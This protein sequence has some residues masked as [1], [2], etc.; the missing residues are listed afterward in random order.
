MFFPGNISLPNQIKL[1]ESHHC[2]VLSAQLIY[3]SAFNL[4]LLRRTRWKEHSGDRNYKLRSAWDT[5]ES[6]FKATCKLKFRIQ[7]HSL[8]LE[9][10]WRFFSAALNV[11]NSKLTRGKIVLRHEKSLRKSFLHL[12]NWKRCRQL[13]YPVECLPFWLWDKSFFLSR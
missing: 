2:F 6:S 8:P 7:K 12:N 9:G 5:R 11:V 10:P 1:I 3:K 4:R 13:N